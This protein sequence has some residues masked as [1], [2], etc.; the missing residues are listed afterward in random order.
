LDNNPNAIV[1]IKQ[2][3]Q[4]L[5]VENIETIVSEYP[6]GIDDES[7]DIV[8]LHNALPYVKDKKTPWQK[9]IEF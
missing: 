9:L 3:A 7:V 6:E 5:C 8:C 4:E 2:R 1:D